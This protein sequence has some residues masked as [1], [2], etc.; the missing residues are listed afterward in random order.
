MAVAPV[1]APGSPSIVLSLNQD[2]ETLELLHFRQQQF[3]ESPTKRRCSAHMINIE[4][5]MF[6][7]SEDTHRLPIATSYVTVLTLVTQLCACACTSI[8]NSVHVI[9]PRHPTHPPP[10]YRNNDG[11]PL[12]SG[13][14]AHSF[15]FIVC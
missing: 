1:H 6:Y 12:Q 5:K 13:K 2:P 15:G 8:G 14:A 3:K 9:Y 10:S 4:Q 11:A 7:S